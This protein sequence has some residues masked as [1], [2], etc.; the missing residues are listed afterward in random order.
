M[1]SISV[2]QTWALRARRACA[3]LAHVAVAGHAGH[4][5][6]DHHV[7]GALDAI[8]QA[9]TAAVEVVEL[10]LRD[11]VVDVDGAEGQRALGRHF[12]QAV[13]T[14][15]GLF[16]HPDDLGGL[17]RVP[18]RVHGQLGLDGGVQAGFLFALRVGD[19][20][21]VLLGALAQDHQQ[22]GVAT[23]VQDH[24]RAF[25][26]G[27]SG[28]ELEDAVREVPVFGERFALVRED[29]RAAFDQ[30]R[31]GMV[32]RAED[33]ARGP[34]HAGA[35]GLQRFHQHG[36]LDGHVD[37][38]RDA[39]TLERLALGELFADGHQAGHLGFGDP[40]FLAAPGG[41]G[42][43]GDGVVVQGLVGGVHRQAPDG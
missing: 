29:R 19:D 25:L 9:L 34:A 31:G 11:R 10:A 32:L 36:G 20:G 23:V 15:G 33:V 26:R 37:A 18:G 21:D 12:L 13:H 5:A 28:A 41:K 22:R 42:Q 3:A 8:D 2:T 39:R 7:G 27:A 6:G 17:A 24:V 35:Q 40:D 30:R 14:G 38:A 4:L 1:G 16:G 43:V